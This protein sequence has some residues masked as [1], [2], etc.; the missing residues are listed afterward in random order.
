MLLSEDN[1][2]NLS[3]HKKY[4]VVVRLGEKRILQGAVRKIKER[5]ESPPETRKRKADDA[6]DKRRGKKVAKK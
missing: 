3:L 1:I 2:D 6:A 4:A 5:L